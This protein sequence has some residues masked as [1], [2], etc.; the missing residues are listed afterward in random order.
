MSMDSDDAPYGDQGEVTSVLLEVSDV[1]VQWRADGKMLVARV[2]E[3]PALLKRPPE[4]SPWG[5]PF[6]FGGASGVQQVDPGEVDHPTWWVVYGCADPS[7][8]VTVTVD[9]LTDPPA[10]VRVGQ[11]F[12]CEW[13]SYPSIAYIHR[14]DRPEPHKIRF[15]R[16]AFMPLASY[17]QYT[18]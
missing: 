1:L 4:H 16:P 18:T 6:P 7:V 12:A 3:L 2:D 13:V 10:L 14:G 8:E 17:P 9:G 5:D 11:I 15:I